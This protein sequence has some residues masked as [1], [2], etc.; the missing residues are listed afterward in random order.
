VHRKQL[1]DDVAGATPD[2][3]TTNQVRD[4]EEAVN[5]LNLM[6]LRHSV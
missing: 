5:S 2:E 1:V 3:E 6:H 4:I